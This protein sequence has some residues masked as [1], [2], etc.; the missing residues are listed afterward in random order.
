MK[1]QRLYLVHIQECIEK[2]ETYTQE[3]E[4]AFSSKTQD[5]VIR[6]FEIIGEAAKRLS[7]ETRQLAPNI[8]LGSS[9]QASWMC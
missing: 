8:F 3:G 2:I 9:L 6:N 5:A 1:D 4:S 7:D